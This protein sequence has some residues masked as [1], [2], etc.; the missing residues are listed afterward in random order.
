MRRGKEKKMNIPR[1]RPRPL[2]AK[3]CRDTPLCSLAVLPALLL[4]G[5]RWF[6]TA[7]GIVANGEEPARMAPWRRK[8]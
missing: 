5:G 1:Q 6:S 7:A 3:S 4:R 8:P 2:A